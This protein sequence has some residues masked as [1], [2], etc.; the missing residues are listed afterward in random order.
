V[1]KTRVF[2]L[3]DEKCQG[4]SKMIRLA[5][6]TGI[7]LSHLYRVRSGNRKIS[8]TFIIGVAKAFPEC[9]LDDLFYIGEWAVN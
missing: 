3:W 4:D 5:Q 9:S 7:S 2:H 8:A 1:L 6:A